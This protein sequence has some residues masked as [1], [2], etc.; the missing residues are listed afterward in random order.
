[1][2]VLFSTWT[3]PQPQSFSFFCRSLNAFSTSTLKT[4]RWIGSKVMPGSWIFTNSTRACLAGCVSGSA[5]LRFRFSQHCL[6]VAS[7]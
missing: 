5:P 6:A 4:R 7:E 3:G 2:T 1:M